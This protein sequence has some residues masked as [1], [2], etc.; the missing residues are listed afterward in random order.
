MIKLFVAGNSTY[1][2]RI[3]QA[4]EQTPV[5][6]VF[7]ASDPSTAIDLLERHV[8][9]CHAVLLGF[10]DDRN[11]TL[12]EIA[13]RHDTS[14]IPFVSTNDLIGGYR[15]WTPYKARP[16]IYG[17]E[18]EVIKNH[19]KDIPDI[20]PRTF[21]RTINEPDV[22][23]RVEAARERSRGGVEV[24][25]KIISL[26]SFKGGVGKTAITVALGTSVAALTDLNTVIIDL[27]TTREMGD[28][29]KY[30]GYIGEK[31]GQVRQNAIIWKEFPYEQKADWELVQSYLLKARSRLYVLPGVR[32]L[33]D[34]NLLTPDLIQ[35]ITEVLSRH[36]DLILFDLGNHLTDQAI[37]AMEISNELFLVDTL[38]L[39]EIDSL[40]DFLDNTVPHLELPRSQISIVFNRIIPGLKHDEEDA[41]YHIGTPCIA[42][43]PEDVEVR[44]MLGN[45]STVPFLGGT[46]IPFTRELEKVLLKIFPRQVFN[47][48][49]QKPK[50]GISK[51]LSNLFKGA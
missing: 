36:F 13:F 37:T 17:Q 47:L 4:A 11:K 9:E 32:N 10:D 49:Q 35:K 43:I 41:S 6:I 18:I 31:K 21:E 38:D 8:K 40:K 44:K 51:W 34:N 27:D 33:A 22:S 25:Q 46:D 16:V 28:V 50:S 1:I 26:F 42:A 7:I 5:Q 20:T 39:P 23:A 19:F 30:L 29:V 14:F 15:I 24:R 2:E 45:D 12:I 3:R 48:H